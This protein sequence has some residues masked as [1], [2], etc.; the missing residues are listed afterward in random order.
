[1]STTRGVAAP[2]GTTSYTVRD[3]TGR[4]Q[5]VSCYKYYQLGSEI[6]ESDCLQVFYSGQSARLFELGRPPPSTYLWRRI[7]QAIRRWT[8]ATTSIFWDIYQ[9]PALVIN[10]AHLKYNKQLYM[11][12]HIA[13]DG[14]Q[15]TEARIANRESDLYFPNTGTELPCSRYPWTVF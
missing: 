14:R 9:A 2:S 8:E 5:G 7:P 12:T 10:H 15:A 6:P 11:R 3:I 1:M 13:R 4:S